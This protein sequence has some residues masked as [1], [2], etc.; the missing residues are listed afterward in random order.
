[1]IFLIFLRTRYKRMR[2]DKRSF[3]TLWQ[4][5]DLY[6][7]FGRIQLSVQARILGECFQTMHG[8]VSN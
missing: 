2:R 5:C 3:G 6:E 7:H 4:K 8:Y 1:M